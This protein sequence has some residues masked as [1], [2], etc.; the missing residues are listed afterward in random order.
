MTADEKRKLRVELGQIAEATRLFNYNPS[1]FLLD[2]AQSEPDELISRYVLAKDPSDGF[3]RLYI[4]KRLDLTVENVAWKNRSML[5]EHVVEAARRRLEKAE[6]DVEAQVQRPAGWGR[7]V[8]RDV[9]ELGQGRSDGDEMATTLPD[10]GDAPQV[11]AT[12][13]WGFTPDTWPVITFGLDG[14]RE[15]LIR[16]SRNGDLVLFIGTETADTAAEDR[17]RLLGLAEIGRSFAVD[18]LDAVDPASLHPSQYNDQK[19]FRWPK[20]LA[21]LKAWRFKNPPRVV[22]VLGAQLTYEATVRA[23]LL[24]EADTRAVL[25]LEKEE[26]PI[27]DYPAVSKLR[28]LGE[29]LRGGPTTGPRP[30]TWLGQSGRDASEP[31]FTYAFQFGQRDLWKIGHAKDVLT[32]LAEVGKHVPHEVLHETWHPELQHRWSTEGQA[33]DMEQRVLKL[34]RTPASVGERV[35]CTRKQL[36]AAWYRALVE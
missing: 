6:F 17:G 30:A 12:R 8:E 36:E 23:V 13:V 19:E 1:R 11:F 24:D 4:A 31:A 32:R 16:A 34:L 7:K 25:A 35:R 21:M 33:Y 27:R 26:V 3:T 22:D 15:A 18:T 10:G 28:A 14:N 9:P 2:L 5:P 29:A 20:A